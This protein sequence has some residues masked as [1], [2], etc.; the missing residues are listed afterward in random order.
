MPTSRVFLPLK[1]KD[2]VSF[3]RVEAVEAG[4]HR[5]LDEPIRRS[6]ARLRRQLAQLR[7]ERR[8]PQA[9]P[10]PPARAAPGTLT[11]ADFQRREDRLS[12]FQGE[13]GAKRTGA[14]R[15]VPPKE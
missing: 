1:R 15:F 3:W 4:A 12:L 8:L 5:P 2:R 10:R 7:R 13:V 14:S 6:R 11:V 9:S